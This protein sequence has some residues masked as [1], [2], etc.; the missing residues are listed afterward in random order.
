M[1]ERA[2][3]ME[4]L[5]GELRPFYSAAAANKTTTGIGWAEFK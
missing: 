3:E 4:I 2:L 5:I 1:M